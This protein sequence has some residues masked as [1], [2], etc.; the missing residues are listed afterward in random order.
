MTHVKR[1]G[2]SVA[3]HLARHASSQLVLMENVPPQLLVV[4]LA[5]MAS[6]Y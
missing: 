1:Q 2:N 6:I 3:H 4:T 5:D